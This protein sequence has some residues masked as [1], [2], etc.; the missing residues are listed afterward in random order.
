MF[1]FHEGESETSQKWVSAIIVCWWMLFCC[2]VKVAQENLVY[3]GLGKNP[4]VWMSNRWVR[5]EERSS[6]G[7]DL[8]QSCFVVQ[9]AATGRSAAHSFWWTAGD[10]TNVSLK[11]PFRTLIS[12]MVLSCNQLQHIWVDSH[13]KYPIPWR[14]LTP[15]GATRSVYGIEFVFYLKMSPFDKIVCHSLKTESSGIYMIYIVS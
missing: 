4:V 1:I 12:H 5:F 15:H 7:D 2:V 9:I 11:W 6:K 14:F 13:I 3:E 8:S 10:C